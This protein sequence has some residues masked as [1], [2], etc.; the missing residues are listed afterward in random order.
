MG[1]QTDVKQGH[2]NQ[3][4][5]FV[6]GRNR[7]KGVS[8][9]GAG[10]D[11]T[12]VLFDTTTVPV[13]ASVTYGRTGTLVTVTKTAHGLVTGDVVGIHFSDASGVAA[14]DGNY[15]ITKTGADTFTLTDIN[16]G[17]VATSTAA[18]YVSG[19]NKWLITYENDATDT[20][21]NAPVI[22]GEGVL[23]TKG[24]YALMTNLGAAQ[25]Y[26]G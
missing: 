11:G 25:I 17:T 18:A 10:T 19:G 14:T 3:S 5:F 20:F 21:S 2:L 8:W 6:L 13:T 22:P 24:I 1:M 4:G 9:Y 16:S 15:S 12:L 26:Y 7:V 23:A